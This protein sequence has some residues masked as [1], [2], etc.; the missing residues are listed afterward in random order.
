MR[1]RVERKSDTYIVFV[2]VYENLLYLLDIVVGENIAHVA[3]EA[4]FGHL[5][6]DGVPIVG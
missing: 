6:A 3:L 2:G 4:L 5:N 1:V